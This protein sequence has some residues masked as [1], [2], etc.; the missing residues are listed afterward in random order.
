LGRVPFFLA[1]GSNGRSQLVARR[2]PLAAR[3][4]AFVLRSVALAARSVAF[5]AR[6]VALLARAVSSLPR[7]REHVLAVEQRLELALLPLGLGDV[8]AQGITQTA[9]TIDGASM[10]D[11]I[12]FQRLRVVVSH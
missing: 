2:V 4:V 3:A 12:G 10:F 1:R 6:A 7:V 5:A 9:A 8:L 11:S